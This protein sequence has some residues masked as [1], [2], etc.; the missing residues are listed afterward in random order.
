MQI[1]GNGDV[2]KLASGSP[3]Q[4]N[5]LAKTDRKKDSMKTM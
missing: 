5:H 4:E 1:K 2:L 3:Q